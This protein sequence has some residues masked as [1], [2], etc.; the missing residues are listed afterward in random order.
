MTLSEL[1][2]R[3]TADAKAGAVAAP[4][5]AV[6]RQTQ[7]Q[8]DA[9]PVEERAAILEH[10]AGQP[11]ARADWMAWHMTHAER[12]GVWTEAEVL[13]TKQRTARF[14]KR[15]LALMVA[16]VLACRLVQR[17]R[18]EDD[19]RVCPE[20]ARFTRGACGVGLVP[21]GGG[22]LE[23]LHRCDSFVEGS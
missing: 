19:R 20:C 3:M 11:R 10:E 9:Y 14:T 4:E 16:D 15:G 8:T 21:V 22:G 6:L 12:T 17:D 18:D 7:V 1:L 13:A 5:V 23:V 2:A